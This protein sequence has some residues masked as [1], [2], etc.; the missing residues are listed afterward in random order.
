MRHPS[1]HALSQNVSPLSIAAHACIAATHHG[2][3]R[4]LELRDKLGAQAAEELDGL[5]VGDERA[6]SRVGVGPRAFRAPPE[7][8]LDGGSGGIEVVCLAA[9]GL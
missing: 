3:H 2:H 5:D 1:E 8:P 7:V 4:R 6:A 9:E